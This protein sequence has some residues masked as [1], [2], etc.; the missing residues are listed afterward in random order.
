MTAYL[1]VPV[2]LFLSLFLG[3]DYSL[4]LLPSFVV[5]SLLQ[6]RVLR[7][8]GDLLTPH[9]Q[10]PIALAL[11]YLLPLYFYQYGFLYSL[12]NIEFVLFVAL[13]SLLIFSLGS[14]SAKYIHSRLF[15]SRSLPLRLSTISE[16][17]LYPFAAFLVCFRL[18]LI[19]LGVSLDVTAA[20]VQSSVLSGLNIISD[21]LSF[22][23]FSLFLLK[24]CTTVRT[25]RLP[26]S[27]VVYASIFFLIQALTL[28][29]GKLFLYVYA[30]I[31]ILPPLLGPRAKRSLGVI[32]FLLLA[33]MPFFVQLSQTVREGISVDFNDYFL[34]L[35]LALGRLNMV[36]PFSRSLLASMDGLLAQYPFNNTLFPFVLAVFVPRF[37]W[38]ERP[39][40]SIGGNVGV[41]TGYISSSADTEVTIS[42]PGEIYLNLHNYYPLFWFAY[43]FVIYFV[44]RRLLDSGS[45][46]MLII[47]VFASYNLVFSGVESYFAL[48][49]G[50][51]IKFALTVLPACFF[52]TRRIN[53]TSSVHRL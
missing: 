28:S 24:G 30:S 35:S 42:L 36:E 39:S 51:V 11:Y 21:W 43:G 26:F 34:G 14:L 37:I 9:F 33:V 12:I 23:C 49:V 52:L 5:V 19:L 10:V 47:G 18:V 7:S 17:S 48:R 46:F 4:Y 32:L 40:S 13:N 29:K 44:L 1:H 16:S 22:L 38:P 6:F 25:G 27:E 53:A 15:R 41:A 2:F 20:A 45:P 50:F 8:A 3:P 31:V